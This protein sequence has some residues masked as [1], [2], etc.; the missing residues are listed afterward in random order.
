M[1]L[2]ADDF[3]DHEEF[4]GISGDRSGVRQFF[5]MMRS[6][7]PDFHIDVEEMLVEGDKVAVRMQMSGTHEGTFLGMPPSGRRFSA[8]G[9]DVVR[10][11]DG[12][13]AEHWGVTDTLAMMQQ[14]GGAAR[15]PAQ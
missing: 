8:A 10:V 14:L 7:F 4:P 9:V 5:A 12:K 2:V 6:A 13:A 3:V 15:E 1:A 11:V